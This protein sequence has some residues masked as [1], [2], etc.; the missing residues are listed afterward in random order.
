MEL[1]NQ[2]LMANGRTIWFGASR[3]PRMKPWPRLRPRSKRHLSRFRVASPRTSSASLTT[4]T[5]SS[6]RTHDHQHRCVPLR[7]TVLLRRLQCRSR[8]RLWLR[9]RHRVTFSLSRSLCLPPSF[10]Y[11][12]CWAAAS[13]L[14][15]DGFIST[16]YQGDDDPVPPR[17]LERT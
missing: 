11:A 6:R 4:R 10:Q 9:S 17:Q 12:W 1:Y 14:V 13:G 2:A 15:G 5:S 7:S 8:R 3:V 16:H